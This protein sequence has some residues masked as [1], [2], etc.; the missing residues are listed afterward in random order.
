MNDWIRSLQENNELLIIDKEVD[1]YLEIAHISYLEMKKDNPKA[2]LFT[3]VIDKK[4]GI[5]YK[6]PVL[7][8]IFGSEKKCK[9]IFVS[10]I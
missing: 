6:T 2:I 5:K 1:R 3:N 9:M 10:Q 7:T 8:N 4:T